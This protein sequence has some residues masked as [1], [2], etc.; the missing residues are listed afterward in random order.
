MIS[1]D[2]LAMNKSDFKSIL[3]NLFITKKND[4]F[5]IDSI[6]NRR[7]SY[8][9]FLNLASNIC[10]I[11]S[12]K[13]VQANDS[14]CYLCENSIYSLATYFACLLLR[15][16]VIPIDCNKGEI[17]T[18]EIIDIV[19]PKL[20]LTNFTIKNELKDSDLPP[21]F[22]NIQFDKP[23][24][25]TFTSGTTGKSKGVI[26]SLNDLLM[27]AVSFGY[28]FKFSEANVFFHNFPMAYMAGILNLF[29]L[30]MIHGS[31]IVI[32]PRQST[33]TAIT[34]WN[35]AVKYEANTFWFNPTFLSILLKLD[36]GKVGIEYAKQN[37][38]IACV[39]TA[40]LSIELKTNF[41]NKY[42]IPLF[43][44]YGLTETLF[45][46]TNYPESNTIG[47]VGEELDGVKIL[48]GQDG[49]I[50]AQTPWTVRKYIGLGNHS[51]DYFNTGDY[52][53]FS[54]KTL[55]ITGRKKDIIIKG[56]VNISPQKIESI[57]N[58]FFDEVVIIG[59]PD[60]IL[61]EKIACFFVSDSF[62]ETK[63]KE[64]NA[65]IITD[66]GKEYTIDYFMQL[67]EIPKNIN[68]KIDKLAL[69]KLAK[70]DTKN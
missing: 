53:K 58:V 67:P 37:N 52:G 36:R 1:Q 7:Y 63:K 17:E 30:P 8:G 70:N 48:I 65:K 28:K 66:L 45:L 50:I 43:E 62:N 49:E 46:T 39:G 56:G 2:I 31:K 61:G 15:I 24:L 55:F 33:V 20:I 69:K 29:F 38:L 42:S 25:A 16:L 57:I 40:P 22:D 27:S 12:S 51:E 11:L 23:Y 18:K 32:A 5:I 19:Q 60:N 3:N 9:E 6:E 47:S 14:I 4:L 26:H 21:A 35:D 68:L 64:I 44:S 10:D 41:E 34:F 54:G 59:L 13:K